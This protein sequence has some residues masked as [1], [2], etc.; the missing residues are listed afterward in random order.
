MMRGSRCI[1]DGNGRLSAH[2]IG[3]RS[4]IMPVQVVWDNEDQTVIRY[5]IQGMWTCEEMLNAVA[6]SNSWLD[7]AQSKI[8]FIYD[9][10]E[11]AGVPGGALAQLRRFIG[12]EHPHTGSA[13]VVNPKKSMAMLFARSLLSTVN[14]IYK[15]DW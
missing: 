1:V 12:K 3:R 14:K 9:M 7:A 8:H 15:P 10:R 2:G 13:V 5:I 11:S 4:E 6:L